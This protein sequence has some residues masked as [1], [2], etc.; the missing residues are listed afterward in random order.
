MKKNRIVKLVLWGCCA[1]LCL[2]PAADAA[3]TLRIGGGLAPMENIFKR[4]KP[5]FEAQTGIRLE[6]VDIPPVEAYAELNADR[7]DIAAG[8]MTYNEWKSRVDKTIVEQLEQKQNNLQTKS[9]GVDYVTI[10]AHPT[11]TVKTLTAVQAKQIFT[12]RVTNWQQVG[13]DNLPITVVLGPKTTGLMHE[14]KKA[15]LDGAEYLPNAMY[16]NTAPEM[17]AAVKRVPGAVTIGTLAQVQD[18]TINHIIYPAP[19]RQIYILWKFTSRKREQIQK[20]YEY[21]WTNDAKK[22][23]LSEYPRPDRAVAA[24][25]FPA[26]GLAG[27]GGAF[28]VLAP[29]S[30]PEVVS[31]RSS[32]NDYDNP[33]GQS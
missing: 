25:P 18:N 22:Y 29:P 15:I 19:E 11:V 28:F 14:F 21:L 8:G 17:K 5:H 32:G 9:I 4:I 16:V 23:T 10:Y 20:L 2:A 24:P 33:S 13:G 26:S 1:A 31:S 7:I 3:E 6:L 12:G 27:N 30:G